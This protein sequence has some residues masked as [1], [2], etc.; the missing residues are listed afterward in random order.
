L[1]LRLLSPPP[2]FGKLISGTLPLLRMTR[3]ELSEEIATRTGLSRADAAAALEA[4]LQAIQEAL[5]QGE[6]VTLRGLGR[7]HLKY[8]KSRKGQNIRAKKTIIIPPRLTI[9]FHPS[10]N[11][12][13][14]VQSNPE[15]LKRFEEK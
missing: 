13:K 3:R 15:L 9:S 8:R 14:K 1:G 5:L 7:F 10:P 2:E 6:E 11:L 12:Q 4:A